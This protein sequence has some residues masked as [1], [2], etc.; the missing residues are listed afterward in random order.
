MRVFLSLGLG[1]MLAAVPAS[2]DTEMGAFMTAAGELRDELRLRDSQHGFTGETGTIW[3][4]APSGAFTVSRFLNRKIE[5][6]RQDGQLGDQ[7][8]RAIAQSL[9]AGGFE[10]LPQQIGQPAPVN[11][12]VISVTFGSDSV[13]LMLAP[14]PSDLRSLAARATTRAPEERGVLAIAATVL[15]ATA[16]D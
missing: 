7:Q 3:V 11:A 10:S 6:P 4:I 8:L 14:D 2:A 9:Q 15:E 16:S 12:R 1:M 5:A 13:D